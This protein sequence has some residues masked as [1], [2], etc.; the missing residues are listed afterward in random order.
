MSAQPARP[1]EVL[2]AFVERTLGGVTHYHDRSAP[3]GEAFVWSV[4]RGDETIAWLKRHRH[5]DK[6]RR[7]RRAYER[8]LPPLR[9]PTAPWHGVCPEDPRAVLVGH[10]PGLRGDAEALEDLRPQI[11]REVGRFLRALHDLEI[12][13]DDALPLDA[14]LVERCEGWCDRASGVVEDDRIEAVRELFDGP[15]P[16]DLVRVPCHRDL[17]LRNVIIDPR[18]EG[19]VAT[20]IDFGQARMDVW[21]SDLVKLLEVSADVDPRQRRSLMDGYGRRLTD[22][23]MVLL[24]RLR[25]LHGLATTVWGADH[26]DPRAQVLGE[27]ILEDVFDG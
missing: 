23:E 27:R 9:C 13:D 8:W 24:R 4:H 2:T 17:Q 16:D 15:W 5:R 26:G 6:A 1:P 3:H 25:A 7:E 21:L 10:V 20:V 12:D 19:L 18:P 11:W 22:K 14:A